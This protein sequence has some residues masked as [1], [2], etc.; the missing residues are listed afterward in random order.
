[1]FLRALIPEGL[2]GVVG[3]F[4]LVTL[5]NLAYS[6]WFLQ[7]AYPGFKEKVTNP[8]KPCS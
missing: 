5:K 7:I 8:D 1:V 4:Q 6:G 3:S 2:K